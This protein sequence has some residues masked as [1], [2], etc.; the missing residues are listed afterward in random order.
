MLFAL[1]GFAKFG[2]QKYNECVSV[3][4]LV[5]GASFATAGSILQDYRQR[6]LVARLI[7]KQRQPSSYTIVDAIKN[8]DFMAT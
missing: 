3:I 4:N 8:S 2:S 7:A 6:L 5:L 1:I